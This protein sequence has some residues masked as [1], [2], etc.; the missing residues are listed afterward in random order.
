MFGRSEADLF[1]MTH[2]QNG[3]RLRVN[4]VAGHVAT[5]TEVDD[6]VSELIIHVINGSSDARLPF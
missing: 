5:V 1:L 3:D 2:R 4:A 6:P